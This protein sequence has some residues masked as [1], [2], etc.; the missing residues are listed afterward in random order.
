MF[1][2]VALTTIGMVGCVSNPDEVTLATEQQVA[3]Y[4]KREYGD[5][6]VF[7]KETGSNS[8]TYRLKDDE[9]GFEYSVTS[10]ATAIWV[11]GVDGYVEETVSSFYKETK[12]DNF[13]A[14]Y[15]RC[16]EDTYGEDIK[17]VSAGHR[18]DVQLFRNCDFITVAAGNE[19]RVF[20][21]CRD[22]WDI[23]TGYDQRGHWKD[24]KIS[25]CVGGEYI[26]SYN[27]QFI[28]REQE[29][30][31]DILYSAAVEMKEPIRLLRFIR[32]ETVPMREFV[33]M[34]PGRIVDVV[35][36]GSDDRMI[37]VYYFSFRE[38]EYFITDVLV[39]R[40]GGIVHFGSHLGK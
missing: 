23:V 22:V 17:A 4:V 37:T 16:F 8:V 27:G 26:G 35:A 19:D 24:E 15:R 29:E 18:V 34:E 11:D 21:A 33:G 31:D 5:A 10:A 13:E 2:M 12:T 30:I 32:K 25:V 39:N 14:A 9:Y 20:E 7:S 28:D 3:R 40:G 6:T 38:N 1:A 36:T